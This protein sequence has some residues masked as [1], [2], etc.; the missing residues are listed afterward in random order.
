MFRFLRSPRTLG[1]TPEYPGS[2]ALSCSDLVVCEARDGSR[3]SASLPG[4]RS[5]RL[6][7]LLLGDGESLHHRHV[8][9]P[10]GA[11]L[12]HIVS[13]TASPAPEHTGPL[14]FLAEPGTQ[15]P[16]QGPRGTCHRIGG[17]SSLLPIAWRC[18]AYSKNLAGNTASPNGRTSLVYLGGPIESGSS[19]LLS[20]VSDARS[21]RL[22]RSRSRRPLVV[23]PTCDRRRISSLDS[24]ATHQIESAG[25]GAQLEFC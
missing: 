9:D 15:F 8:R 12:V 18:S 5:S 22:D 6:H 13:E 10:S 17:G 19:L 11:S 2:P 7:A 23:L 14:S 24:L 1:T 20:Q 16:H 21:G 4:R 3:Q 25:S